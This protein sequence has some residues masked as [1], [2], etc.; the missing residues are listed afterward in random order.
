[1]S[2]LFVL[3][4]ETNGLATTGGE[5]LTPAKLTQAAELLTVF[6]NAYLALYWGVPGGCV[7]RAASSPTDI[8][9]NQWP[10]HLRPTIPEAPGGL[11]TTRS[12]AWA[13]PTSRMASTCPTR[14]SGPAAPFVAW[15]HEIAEALI[16]PGTDGAC[17]DGT[18]AS[19]PTKA[20]A[21]EVGDPVE[22]SSFSITLPSGASGYLTNFVLPSYFVPNHA[23]PFD[24]MTQLG[25]QAAA[26]GPPAP[27]TCAPANGGNDQNLHLDWRR[28]ASHRDGRHLAPR[29]P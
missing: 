24:Y 18:G 14:S 9:P 16:D 19:G 23:G 7:V 15:S 10:F 20:F 25:L 6:V 22:S 8:Q 5:S 27:L 2:T 17:T 21:K 28:H 1:M 4:D 26:A 3:I 29:K 12:T 11:P 13:C